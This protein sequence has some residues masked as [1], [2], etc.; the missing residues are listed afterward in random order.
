MTPDVAHPRDSSTESAADIDLLAGLWQEAP[1]A[2]LPSDAPPELKASIQNIENPTR[3]YAIH[4]ASRR[5]GFQLLV[6]RPRNHANPKSR[7][8]STDTNHL[9]GGKDESKTAKV[10]QVNGLLRDKSS[11][12]KSSKNTSGRGIPEVPLKPGFFENVSKPSAQPLL[13]ATLSPISPGEAF[14]EP[15]PKP[16][17]R[18]RHHKDDTRAQESGNSG[19]VPLADPCYSLSSALP[20]GLPQLDVDLV[21]FICNVY[22]EDG[23]SESTFAAAFEINHSYPKPVG[24]R[25]ALNRRSVPSTPGSRTQWKRFNEQTL[26]NVLM[27]PQTVVQSFSHDQ[28]LY[29]SQ[30]LWY[31]FHRLSRVASNLVFHSLWLAAGRLFVPPQDLNTNSTAKRSESKPQKRINQLSNIDAGYLMSICMHALVAAAPIVPDSRTLY[32][33]S[34][35]RSNGLTLAGGSAIARQ[36]PSRCLDYDD[37]FSNDLAVRLARRLFCAI[38]A[39]RYFADKTRAAN[40][41]DESGNI[42]SDVLQ[43]LV[44]QLDFLS[45]GSASMLEFPQSERLLHETRVPTVLLDWARTIILNEWDGRADFAMDG[46]FGGALSFVETLRM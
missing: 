18:N 17:I 12:A 37:A 2:R 43:P 23:T 15:K 29:D 31:C 25:K 10:S 33:M 16:D 32:E 27:D 26:F 4:R 19:E 3:V 44:E 45:T 35:I 7:K 36:P 13:P 11:R 41:S 39:R 24:R 30:T 9:V 34:R 42:E 46:P 28:K 40:S 20:Q 5:H 21:D 22:E 6:E 38:T 8:R 1:F 14:D